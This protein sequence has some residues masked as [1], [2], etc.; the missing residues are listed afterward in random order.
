MQVCDLPT[1]GVKTVVARGGRGGDHSTPNWHGLPGQR[2]VF[3]LKLKS[4]A[5]VGLV[6]YVVANLSPGGGIKCARSFPNAGKST[7]LQALSKATPKIGNYPCNCSGH[8]A[9]MRCMRSVLL[10]QSLL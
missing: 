10:F 3:V 8:I 5:D 9:D 7:L 1:S 6:G 2:G 4:I